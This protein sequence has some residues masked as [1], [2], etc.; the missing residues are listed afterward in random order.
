M[1]LLILALLC[2][3][4]IVTKQYGYVLEKTDEGGTE[5]SDY[6][7]IDID[8]ECWEVEADDLE[9]DDEV[10]C[11]FYKDITIATIYGWR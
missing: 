3:F 6:Y 5:F 8:G 11:Y 9:E 7:L 2:N 10:T 1:K 4:G